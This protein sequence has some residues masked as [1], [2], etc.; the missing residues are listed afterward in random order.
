M[1]GICATY[2]QDD[3][4]PRGG[5]NISLPPV[6]QDDGHKTKDACGDEEG[7]PITMITGNERRG[8]GSASSD[9]DSSVKVCRPDELHLQKRPGL[10]CLHM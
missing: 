6:Q 10:R 2:I 8:D 1:V 3:G 7:S 4:S 5:D 9:V